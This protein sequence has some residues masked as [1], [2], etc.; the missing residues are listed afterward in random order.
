[1]MRFPIESYISGENCVTLLYLHKMLFHF[2]IQKYGQILCVCKPSFLMPADKL[3][4]YGYSHFK[5]L[6]VMYIIA[7]F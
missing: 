3:C 6:A 1:M 5:A 4:N 2:E 7:I